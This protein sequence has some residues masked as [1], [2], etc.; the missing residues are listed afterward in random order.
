MLET[1]L[2]LSPLRRSLVHASTT[3]SLKA[4][5]TL[6]LYTAYIGPLHQFLRSQLS[7][8]STAEINKDQAKID[9]LV[10]SPGF[11]KKFDAIAYPFD[12]VKKLWGVNVDGTYLSATSVARHLME[13][14]AQ[15]SVVMTGP[16]SSA[17][18][19]VPQTNHGQ[20]QI[21]FSTGFAEKE[22]NMTSRLGSEDNQAR[23]AYFLGHSYKTTRS[24][25][26]THRNCKPNPPNSE[27]ELAQETI[28]QGDLVLSDRI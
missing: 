15:Y 1:P 11:T 28:K 27:V 2:S 9:H 23:Y 25:S 24:N 22:M 20:G 8:Q 6:V 19:N 13:R 18:V 5:R 21:A 26:N 7:Q 4:R 14:K 3:N 16:I 12:R 17:V 10:N